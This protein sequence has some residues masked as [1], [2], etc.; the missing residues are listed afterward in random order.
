MSQKVIIPLAAAA[1]L[2]L[3]LIFTSCGTG[4]TQQQGLP[5]R[6]KVLTSIAVTAPVSIPVTAPCLLSTESEIRLS[7]KTGG[8]IGSIDVREGDLVTAGQRLASLDLSE[9][10]S[11]VSQHR[12]ALEKAERDLERTKNLYADNATTLQTVQNVETARYMAEAALEA[13]L[14]N[15]DRSVIEAPANGRVLRKLA[16]TGEITA[17]GHPVLLFAPTGGGWVVTAALSD[18]QVVRIAEGDRAVVTLDA[19][20]QEEF[21]ARVTETSHIA[22]PYTGTFTTKAALTVSDREFRT[23]MTGRV[24]IYPS[25]REHLMTVP[26]NVLTPAGENAAYIYTV[27]GDGFR[28]KRVTTGAITGNRVVITGG[29]PEGTLYITEGRHQLSPGSKIELQTEKE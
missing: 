16:E 11:M 9:I 21:E 28:K 14:F 13:A 5:P 12:L 17:S 3:A 24:S 8:I 22:S 25:E 26:I 10:N 19:F 20:P 4:T 1:M 23:G 6:V 15:R 29:L 18:K 2:I 27:H 7:F